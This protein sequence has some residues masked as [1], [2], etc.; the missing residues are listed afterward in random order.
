MHESEGEEVYLDYA[1]TAPLCEAAF[2]AMQEHMRWGRAGT[3]LAN[4]NSLHTPGRKAFAALEEARRTIAHTL[5]ATRPD[6]IIFTSG[7]TEADNAALIG[8]AEAKVRERR[9]KGE[10][11][12]RPHV[13]TS[14]I[15]HDAVK[16][17][18]KELSRRGYDITSVRP[19]RAGFVEVRALEDALR[20]ETVLVSIQTANSEIGSIQPIEQLAEV[21]HEHGCSFHTDATQALGK[22]ELDL[23]TLGI[24]AASF[25]AHKIG[26]PRGV[27]ALFLKRRTPFLP[28]MVGGGQESGR[29]SGTQNVCGVVGFAAALVAACADIEMSAA[30]LCV[31]RDKLYCDLA[32]FPAIEPTV[33]VD[34]G[35][36]DYLCNIVNVM[37]DGLESESAVLRYDELGFAVSGG[38]ACS[39]HSLE[40][41]SVIRA[42]GI[43]ADRAHT[44]C[45]ISFGEYTTLDDINGFLRATAEVLSWDR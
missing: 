7:A 36:R 20:D 5:G 16:Q 40:P 31:L 10:K 13:V 29:R 42:L 11:L 35:S 18:C 30:R 8:I 1:A 22:V 25:S 19:N 24:D 2:A 33:E 26:G 37:I 38:S 6:E 39:S 43:D 23:G 12:N 21:A 32:S 28:T 15:E 41:S 27:G 9:Q 44:T 34:K 45:R 4:P 14:A 17:A 3:N